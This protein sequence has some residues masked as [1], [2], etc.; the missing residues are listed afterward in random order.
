[1][2]IIQGVYEFKS[3]KQTV[4]TIGTFDGVHIGHQQI[5][6]H[7]IETA[8][9]NDLRSC[10]LTF[11]PHPRMVLQKDSGIKMIQ[12]I[13]EK[14]EKLREIGL[15]YLVI[16]P[17]SKEFSRLTAQT[18]IEDILVKK[19]QTKKIIIGYDH[20][21]G[22]NRA[23]DINDLRAYSKEFDFEV[24]EISA[25]AIEEITVSSTKIRTA[26]M[27]GHIEE[28]N[29]FLGYEF[30]FSG[31]VVKGKALGK[32]IGFPTANLKLENPFK[33][34]P[35]NGVYAVRVLIDEQLHEG[36]MNIGVNPTILESDLSKLKIEIH[37]FDFNRNIYGKQVKVSLSKFIRDEHKFESVEALKHQIITDQQQIQSHFET[38]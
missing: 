38:H 6:K 37:L 7:L 36:M 31:T 25:Q 19:L 15:D 33:L 4:L 29:Q 23:A 21:F 20:R 17:F 8:K 27:D 28:A 35:K 13:E 9:A 18:Y 14:I 16:H 34:I 10:L 1:V 3:D 12:S 2:E 11:Y 32:Q 22:K 26:L 5:L 24:I 30:H